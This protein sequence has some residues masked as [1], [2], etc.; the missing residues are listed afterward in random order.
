MSV[1]RDKICHCRDIT[2]GDLKSAL[3]GLENPTFELLLKTT[4]AGSECSACLLDLECFY[5][6]ATAR[7]FEDG[8][9]LLKNVTSG[10]KKSDGKTLKQ[11]IYSF[12]DALLPDVPRRGHLRMPFLF[13]DGIDQEIIFSNQGVG[14]LAK[15]EI[16][17]Y[18][19]WIKLRDKRG[20]ALAATNFELLSGDNKHISISE[21]MNGKLLPAVDGSFDIGTI[22]VKRQSTSRGFYGTTR[23]HTLIKM[24]GGIASVH[25]GLPNTTR[26]NSTRW[27]YNP[28]GQRM[29]ISFVNWWPVKTAVRLRFPI[30]DGL[31]ITDTPVPQI[32]NMIIPPNG[33]V[34]HEINIPKEYQEKCGI[35]EGQTFTL[36]FDISKGAH[37][38]HMY[39]AT[40]DLN[41]ISIDHL[42]A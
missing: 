14:Y 4:G 20:N 34:L 35:Q 17:S 8:V 41:C 11:K 5:T 28:G 23:A 7:P 27:V 25:M 40:P 33:A 19:I 21:I 38:A 6:E 15:P 30:F 16:A 1:R 37:C 10:D 12:V 18:K 9:M 36:N 22:E 31:E 3:S 26:Q 42:G 24:P 39:Y 29:F 2:E 13:G 32:V